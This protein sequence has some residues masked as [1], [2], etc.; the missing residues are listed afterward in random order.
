MAFDSTR[1]IG[2]V[3]KFYRDW[4]LGDDTRFLVVPSLEEALLLAHRRGTDPRWRKS[5]EV[6]NQTWGAPRLRDYLDGV[7][8]IHD[9]VYR[10]ASA[11]TRTNH[12]AGWWQYE[13][14][15]ADHL[16]HKSP[17]IAEACRYGLVWLIPIPGAAL[18]V[19]MPLVRCAEGR[20]NVL[21]D[22]TG[23]MAV[24][25][26]DGTGCYF[27][28]G[29][30]FDKPLYD[31]VIGH[32]LLI[33]DIAAL[34]NVDQRAIAML[35]L[36]FEQLVSDSGAELLDTGAKGTSLYRLPL[37]PRI[38]DDR[39]QN[40]GRFDYFIHMRDASH[41]EREFIEWVDPKV[42]VQRNAELCQAH[43]FGISLDQWLAIEQEG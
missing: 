13:P 23:R 25:W 8:D 22:D 36:T 7:H 28:H 32:Q 29:T 20:R 30:E 38:A 35:Y 40:Y 27:L 43:A 39:E 42:G 16:G 14:F 34:D 12:R 18:I 31:R 37:H 17:A 9:Q 33:H 26:P 19:A 4:G 2:L 21:H 1:V 15:S 6:W 11:H 5:R 24:E 41:P 10:A 3:T